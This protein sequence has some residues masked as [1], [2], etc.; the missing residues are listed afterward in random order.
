MLRNLLGVATAAI[1]AVA[2]G[3]LGPAAGQSALPRGGPDRRFPPDAR[4]PRPTS[5]TTTSEPSGMPQ[6]MPTSIPADMEKGP[7]SGWQADTMVKYEFAGDSTQTLR[8]VRA[9]SNSVTIRITSSI[10]GVHP[11]EARRARWLTPD[12][13]KR[14]MGGFGTKTGQGTLKVGDADLLCDIYTKEMTFDRRRV[15]TK[16]WLCK[17]VP[18]WTVRVDN[19]ATGEMKTIQRVVQYTPLESATP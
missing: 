17:E 10:E 11:T 9:D 4:R 18:G 12:Q 13:L 16:T 19:D 14:T 5:P 3:A 2:A 1:L 15:T 6:S 7:W 8:F